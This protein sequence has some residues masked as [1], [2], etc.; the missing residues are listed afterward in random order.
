ML[1]NFK[2]TE[3]PKIQREEEDKAMKYDKKFFGGSGFPF[4]SYVSYLS[5]VR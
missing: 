1:K 2:K 3:K 4:H 5:S